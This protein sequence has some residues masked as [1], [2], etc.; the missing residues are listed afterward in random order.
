MGERAATNEVINRLLLLLGDTN[1]PVRRSAFKALG[2]MGE[3]AANNEVINRLLRLLGHTDYWVR[4]DSCEALNK[5]GEIAAISNVLEVLLDAGCVNEFGM[6]DIIDERTEEMFDWFPCMLNV[7]EVSA[8]DTDLSH[9]KNCWIRKNSYPEKFIKVFL[10]TKLSFWFPIIA[11]LSIDGGY[12]ITVTE[13][14]VVVYG[15]NERL[16]L[17]FSD[18]ELGQRLHD[19]LFNW[20]DK[21][22]KRLESGLWSEQ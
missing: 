2:K 7:E 6:R 9:D 11:R 4:R 19:Y 1:A 3:R 8:D 15:S 12:A 20:L 13:N 16:E 18:G 22:L 14:T 10:N 17:P 5:S 21:S